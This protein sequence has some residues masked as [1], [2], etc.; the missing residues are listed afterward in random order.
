MT[1]EE[2]YEKFLRTR[3]FRDFPAASAI[4]NDAKRSTADRFWSVMEKLAI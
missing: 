2:Q 4:A 1:T 3:D